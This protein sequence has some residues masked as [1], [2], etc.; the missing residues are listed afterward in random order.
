M[1]NYW[2]LGVR[3]L[4]VFSLLPLAVGMILGVLGW[5]WKQD[6]GALL[7]N[8]REVD[9]RVVKA[10]QVSGGAELE[11]EFRTE[12]GLP[13]KKTLVVDERQARD[14]DA[15]GKL[16]LIHDRRDPATAEVGHVVSAYNA[17]LFYWS[18]VGIGAVLVLWGIGVMGRAAKSIL[19][20]DGLF[21]EGQLAQTEVR[22]STLAPGGEVGRFTYAFRGPDGR[23]YEG[24]SPDLPAAQLAQWPVGKRLTVAFD[25]K[26]PR[27]SEPDIF[28]IVE[29]N[30]RSAEL[31]A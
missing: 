7:A 29:T 14:A 4:L 24:K 23:W 18:L 28:G 25:T 19:R 9:G 30:K 21:R 2:V 17:W 1:I 27:E 11:V 22:D 26:N 3:R 16:S 15:V 12:A 6:A 20:I 8:I 5:M 10:T 31:P 13:Y